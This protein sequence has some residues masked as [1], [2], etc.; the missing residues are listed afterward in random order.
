[1]YRWLLRALSLLIIAAVGCTNGVNGVGRYDTTAMQEA[2]HCP[3]PSATEAVL[4]PSDVYQSH[5]IRID[6]EKLA[7]RPD[8]DKADIGYIDRVV[9]NP[10]MLEQVYFDATRGNP[11]ASYSVCHFEVGARHL[12]REAARYLTGLKCQYIANCNIKF[13]D[14]PI[15]ETTASG[16][17]LRSII[18]ETFEAEARRRQIRQNLIAHALILFVGVKVASTVYTGPV[19]PSLPGAVSGPVRG[20]R[21]HRAFTRAMGPA[22]PGKQWHHIVEQTPG[23]VTRFG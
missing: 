18:G 15:A 16:F 3:A 9:R 12:G 22:G 2:A 11:Q 1:M 4:R 5:G 23:N 10:R 20:F 14:L 21:S 13:H 19:A 17:R 8:P 6:Y 7:P